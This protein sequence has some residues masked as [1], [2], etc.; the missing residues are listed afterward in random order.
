MSH[1]LLN[2]YFEAANVD[3]QD[4]VEYKEG[5]IPLLFSEFDMRFAKAA[6]DSS[7]TLV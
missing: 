7:R 6:S 3:V 5:H 2:L 4:E 1:H